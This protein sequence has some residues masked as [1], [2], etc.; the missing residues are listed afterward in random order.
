MKRLVLL[1]ALLFAGCAHTPTFTYTKTPSTYISHKKV[2]PVYI[3]GSFSTEDQTAILGVIQEWNQALNGYIVLDVVS[4]SL[5]VS[6][7]SDQAMKMVMSAK[8]SHGLMIIRI[9]STAMFIP[10]DDWNT[11]YAWTTVNETYLIRDRIQDEQVSFIVR[12]EIGHYLG[13]YH[14]HQLGTLMDE[15][16]N[17]AIQAC[18]D[19]VTMQ[20]IADE[21]GLD[22]GSLNYCKRF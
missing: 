18:I 7:E 3:D 14:S 8:N 13:W 15:H 10:K 4:R 9:D 22:I 11:D 6:V 17:E 5:D 21:N 20:R 1:S 2:L 12:H 19:Q 16:Y